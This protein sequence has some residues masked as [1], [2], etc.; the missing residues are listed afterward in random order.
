MRLVILVQV[1]HALGTFTQLARIMM[2]NNAAEAAASR[3]R[4]SHPQGGVGKQGLGLPINKAPR[5]CRRRSRDPPWLGP[6][7]LRSRVP[8]TGAYRYIVETVGA[9][10]VFPQLASVCVFKGYLPGLD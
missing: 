10:C 1:H 6:L 5:S 7:F 2:R 3:I 8:A 4:C 9:V